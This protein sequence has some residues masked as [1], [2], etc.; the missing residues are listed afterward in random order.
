MKRIGAIL[1]VLMLTFGAS[2]QE[3]NCQVTIINDPSLEVTSVEQEIFKQLEETV[4]DIM[5]TRKWTN[6]NFEVEERI[7]CQLQFQ[8]NSIPAPNSFSGF[9]QVQSSR[10][11][12]NSSY[13]TVI[14]NYQDDDLAFT[15]SRGAVLNFSENQFRDNL[16][17]MLAFYAYYI[18]GMDYD[19]FSKE[20]G[21][22]YFQKAQEVV[23]LA[24]TS[25]APGWKSNQTGKRNRYWLVD[26]V[27]HELFSPLRTCNY[28]YHRKGIDK[29]Y[30]NKEEGRV[31]IY[32]ALNRL[33]KVVSTRPNSLNLLNFI[34]AK[35]NEL[36]SLY[37]DAEVREKTK[38]VNLLKRLDPANSSKY[39]EILG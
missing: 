28:E 11:G 25:S 37:E 13:N 17:S 6:D 26:N 1:S 30:E 2:A 20:G 31:N 29:L 33:V 18:I 7:N 32:N 10:P 16:T 9:L 12:F 39:Q 5:N 24:Q 14:F 35:T 36:K 38:I 22:K 8:I 15:Y 23:T 3:L 21:T 27:L 4:Y 34:Q 19:S